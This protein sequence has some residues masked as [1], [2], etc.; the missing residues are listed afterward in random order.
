MLWTSSAYLLRHQKL[1]WITTLPALFMTTVVISFLLNSDTLG[2]GLSMMISTFT[3]IVISL[4]IMRLIITKNKQKAI[5][6]ASIKVPV[7]E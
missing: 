6:E 4:G 2:A 5:E 7:E 3:G 1:H